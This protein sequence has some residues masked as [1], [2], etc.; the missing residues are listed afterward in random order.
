MKIKDVCARQVVLID[1]NASLRRA[2]ENLAGEEIGV[3][4]VEQ[5]GEVCGVLSEHDIVE[6]F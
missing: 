1:R 4:V 3:L 6:P 2:T 5:A